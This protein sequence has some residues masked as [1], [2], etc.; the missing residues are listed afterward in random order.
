MSEETNLWSAQETVVP[1]PYHAPNT[2]FWGYIPHKAPRPVAPDDPYRLSTVKIWCFAPGNSNAVGA[3]TG[4]FIASDVILTVGHVLYDPSAFSPQREGGYVDAVQIESTWL[5]IPA[6][7][8]RTNRVVATPGWAQAHPVAAGDLGVI[9]LNASVPSI[10]ALTPQALSDS[11]LSGK[12]I[13]VYGYPA[14]SRRLFR[15]EGKCLALLPQLIFHN[16]HVGDGDSGSPLL[17][18]M[19]GGSAL[20]GLHR[21]G[22]AETPSGLPDSVS[23]F[24]FTQPAIDWVNALIPQL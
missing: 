1:A 14:I 6:A 9:R 5:N 13:T 24:R 23:A 2:K 3:G 17:E 20:A 19:G 12:D 10:K 22:P 21:A 18:P 4:V 11:A 16:A 8:A 15:S 7:A